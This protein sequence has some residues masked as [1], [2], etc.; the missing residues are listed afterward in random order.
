M[1][2]VDWDIHFTRYPFIGNPDIGNKWDAPI[3][4][5]KTKNLFFDKHQCTSDY[6]I[7]EI[8][9]LLDVVKFLELGI[10]KTQNPHGFAIGG[11]VF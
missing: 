2:D 10:G 3:P 11:G 8:E 5:V 1:K 7:T 6:S 9:F 4:K